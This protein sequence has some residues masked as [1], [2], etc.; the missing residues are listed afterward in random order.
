MDRVGERLPAFDRRGDVQDDDLVD[1]LPVIPFGE[2]GGITSP[3]KPLE[4]DALHDR[5]ITDVEAGD[6]PFREHDQT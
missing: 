4:L 3:A 1:P 5:P 6:D 2:L